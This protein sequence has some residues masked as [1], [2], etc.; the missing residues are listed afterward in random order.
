MGNY[1]LAHYGILGQR[2]GVRRTRD[3][4]NRLSREDTR[5][6][7]K[8]SEK[9]TR[10]AEKAVS[11]E[12]SSYINQLASNP[13]A[14]NKTGRLNAATINAYN[15][16]KAELMNMQ[17][18]DL[19]SPSGKVVQF[20]AKRGEIGVM[21]ALHDQGYNIDQLKNGVYTSGKVAYR[22]TTLNKAEV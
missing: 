5:W 3:Q 10:A 9:V 17:I 20:V 7:K 18:R 1:E 16:K 11:G 4:L 12:L 2:W 19:R 13:N 21:M 6:A 14:Y 22:K 15:K 8:N